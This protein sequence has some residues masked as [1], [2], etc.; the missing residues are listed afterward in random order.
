MSPKDSW[1]RCLA[2]AKQVFDVVRSVRALSGQPSAGSYVWASFQ[3]T[4]LF[5]EYQLH[6]WG[7]HPKTSSILARTA[8]R[9]EGKALEDLAAKVQSHTTLVNRHAGD[10]KELQKDVKALKMKQGNYPQP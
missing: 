8:M 2:Y 7:E 3:T 4:E 10:I 9:K 1:I 6:N 5:K